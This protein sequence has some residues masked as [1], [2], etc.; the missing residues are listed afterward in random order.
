MNK[1]HF[2][3]F[4]E[5][6]IVKSL[7]S[8]EWADQNREC[9]NKYSFIGNDIPTSNEID[10]YLVTERGFTLVADSEKFVCFKLVD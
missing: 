4:W 9:F 7:R 5:N 1:K 8:K 6:G 2:V 10:R 3:I